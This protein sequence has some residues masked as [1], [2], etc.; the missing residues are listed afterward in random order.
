MTA[1]YFLVSQ[2]SCESS[3]CPSNSTCQSGFGNQ[4]YRCVCPVGYRGNKSELG[5]EGNRH[6]EKC[7]F[8]NIH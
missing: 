3:P 8:E 4:G 7:L 6:F 1:I 2:N 5:K